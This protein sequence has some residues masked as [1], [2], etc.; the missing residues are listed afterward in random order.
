MKKIWLT[1]AC[2]ALAVSGCGTKDPPKDAVAVAGDRAIESKELNRSYALHPQWKRG[3]T[4]LQSYLTQL[5]ALVAQKLYAQEAEKEGLD[6]DSLM[7]GYLRFVK[8]K[9]MIKGLYRREVRSKV[10]I[11]EAE[12]RRV[13]EWMKKKVDYEYIYARDSGRCA[14]CTK[15]LRNQGINAVII[16]PDSSLRT[17]RE[18][19]GTV[20][21]VPRELEAFLFG[22][23]LN[24]IMGPIRSG[25]G[26]AMVKIVGGRVDKFLSENDFIEQKEKIDKLLADQKSDSIASHYVA[27]LMRDKDLRLNANVFWQVAEYF[28]QRVKEEHID[29]MNMRSVAV[30]GDEIQLLAVDLNAISNEVVATHRDGTLTVKELIDALAVMPGSLRPRVRTPQNLKDAI[31]GIVRNQYLFKQATRE[32]LAD[33]PEVLYEY[34]LQRDETL[35]N[36]YYE[37]RRGQTSVTPA[38]VDLYKH[39]APVSEEQVFF[40]FNMTALARD[41]KVDSILRAE[42]PALEQRYHTLLD[43]ARVRGML[44]TPDAVI[45]E[46]PIPIYIREIFM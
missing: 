45:Q 15:I 30:T 36:A 37:R 41:A 10:Q 44:K 11:S 6:R 12:E 3:E 22:G 20:G 34:N 21:N 25:G 2:A 39:Q 35:A 17:G 14:S 19:G 29:P 1:F 13:Y 31:G 28:R 5:G 24:D 18:I 42:L 38:D 16:P 23:K 40:K 7:S 33:D 4:Q 26:Y 9:E 46:N 8:E 27:T 43:T 32:G